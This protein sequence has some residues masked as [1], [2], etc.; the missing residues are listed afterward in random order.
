MSLGLALKLANA[1]LFKGVGVLRFTTS[2]PPSVSYSR[3][4]ASTALTSGG[5]IVPFVANAPP[6]TDRGLLL[7]PAATNLALRSQALDNVSWT[8]NGSTITLDAAPG[9]DGTTTMNKIVESAAASVHGVSQLLTLVSGAPATQSVVA[10]A[11]ERTWMSMTEGNNV[12]ATAWFNLATG[13]V[14]TV[15]GTG[16]PSAAILPLAG[17][18]YRC[19]LRFTPIA[20]AGNIQIRNATGDGAWSYTGDGA[21]GIYA[22]FGDLEAGSVTSPISTTS[23]S[24]TRG[25][26]ACSVTVPTGKTVARVTYGVS[27]T[28]VDITG[29][30]PG[31]SFDLV[32]GRPWL[33]LGNELKT[34]EWRP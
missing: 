3:T 27:N 30:T 11:G 9:P 15:S 22:Y 2:L 5:V 8:K 31:A 10:K 25:L 33:G 21:S 7:E 29:L 4:G 19:S 17:G 34:L 6:I 18:A 28:V 24:A 1:T 26:P 12:T 32:T 23:A 20:A 16:S 14:G 13:A